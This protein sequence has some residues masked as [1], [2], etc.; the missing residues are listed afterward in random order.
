M[1]TILHVAFVIQAVI[2]RAQSFSWPSW[3]QNEHCYERIA[4]CESYMSNNPTCSV[5]GGHLGSSGFIILSTENEIEIEGRSVLQL[6]SGGIVASGNVWSTTI[7]M[8][9]STSVVT[10]SYNLDLKVCPSSIS[11]VNSATTI[12]A[13]FRFQ[14][15]DGVVQPDQTGIVYFK[16]LKTCSNSQFSNVLVIA[17]RQGNGVAT[18]KANYSTSVTPIMFAI[19]MH[20]NLTM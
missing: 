16:N 15:E 13:T 20:R 17:I 14:C 8:H 9:E 19:V 7:G 2:Y 4:V 11:L 12:T 6:P 10:P 3:T 18:I 1:T 5:Q